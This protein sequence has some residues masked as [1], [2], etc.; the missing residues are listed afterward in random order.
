[1]FFVEKLEPVIILNFTLDDNVYYFNLYK[2]VQIQRIIKK[3]GR[4]IKFSN[5]CSHPNN[6]YKKIP[7][8]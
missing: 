5:N 1:M 6:N 2:V 4:F 7:L 8:S 3:R